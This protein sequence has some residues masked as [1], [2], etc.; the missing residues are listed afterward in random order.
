[1]KIF[2]TGG[3]GFIGTYLAK[4]LADRGDDVVVYDNMFNFIH[5]EKSTYYHMLLW[6][7]NYLNNKVKIVRGDIRVQKT[8]I[9]CIKD[10]NPDAIV[11][12]AALAVAQK[13]REFPDEATTINVNGTLN[14]LESVRELKN[15][16]KMIFFSSSFVYGH[17]KYEPADEVHS[18]DPIDI[19]GGTKL[20][21]EIFTKTYCKELSFPYV[22]IRPS[23]VYGYGD[24]NQRVSGLLIENAYKG[25]PLIL[26]DET[27]RL[28]FTYVEDLVQGTIL[29]IDSEKANNETFNLTC[30]RARTLKEYA[31]ILKGIFPNLKI[32]KK[33]PDIIRPKRGTLDIKKAVKLL[34][35]KPRYSIEE[36]I[37]EYADRIKKYGILADS[38]M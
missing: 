32:E 5:P 19:Y 37:K 28:D 13:T 31:E 14:V 3:L 11:H 10:F 25:K 22:I 7:L 6:R 27:S 9:R 12:L 35:Y 8:L 36:G 16:K 23:A 21:G 4:A 20:T 1:M 15:L 30:G 29:C 2:I 34:G 18:L 26:H 33:V 24:A 17:F 38:V